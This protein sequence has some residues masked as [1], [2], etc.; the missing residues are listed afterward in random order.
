MLSEQG[1]SPRPEKP[2]RPFQ[3]AGGDRRPIAAGWKGTGHGPFPGNVK[4]RMER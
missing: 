3:P 1:P 4:E 2:E